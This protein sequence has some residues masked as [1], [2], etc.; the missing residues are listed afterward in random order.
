[1]NDTL[2]TRDLRY[3]L[4]LNSDDYILIIGPDRRIKYTNKAYCTLW[5]TEENDHIGI[6]FTI[7]LPEEKAKWYTE[8]MSRLTVDNPTLS[9]TIKSGR[10]GFREWVSWKVTALFDEQGNLLEVIAIGRNVH[11]A[12]E[13]QQEKEKLLNTLNAFKKAI[14]T[15]IICTITDAKGVITYANHNFC[16]ISK[17]TQDEIHGNTHSIVNSGHHPRSFFA[18]MWRTISSGKMWTGEIKNRAKD[19]SYYWVNSVIIPIK[20]NRK[21][22]AGYLSLRILINKQKQME[23]ERKVYQQSLEEMLFMVSHEIRKPITTCQGLLYIM[24]EDQPRSE[25]EY[26]EFI[27]YLISTA[28]ELNNYSYKLNEYL[29]KNIKRQPYN[30]L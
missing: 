24:Q 23:E 11:D 3:K 28:E 26:N 25:D 8:R 4:F 22:I 10:D 1:M 18:G 29:E 5:R 9:L 30:S 19:G 16:S 12:I 15:N 20:D 14:D 21:R 13:A 7:G 27:S 2:L 6:D 17:Y